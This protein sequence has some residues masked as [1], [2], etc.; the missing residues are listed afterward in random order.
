MYVNYH[1]VVW[2][3]VSQNVLVSGSTRHVPHHDGTARP[4][5]LSWDGKLFLSGYRIQWNNRTAT[6]HTVTHDESLTEKGCAFDS[7]PVAPGKSVTLSFLEPGIYPYYCRL[8]PI[9]RGT[10]IVQRNKIEQ[11]PDQN[12]QM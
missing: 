9:M 2:D 6:A 11:G 8:H 4:L 3:G 5:L 12:G 7:G 1:R 10:M